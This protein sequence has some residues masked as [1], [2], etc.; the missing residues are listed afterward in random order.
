MAATAV[1]NNPDVAYSADI[2][3]RLVANGIMMVV[4]EPITQSVAL[5]PGD[6]IQTTD[7]VNLRLGPGTNYSRILTVQSGDQGVVLDDMNNLNGVLAKGLHWWK[8]RFGSNTGWMAEE[9]LVKLP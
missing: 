6:A 3:Q 7:N 2:L 8:V 5:A 9:F 4:V 1:M